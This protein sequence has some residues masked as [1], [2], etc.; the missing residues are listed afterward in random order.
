MKKLL[1]IVFVFCSYFGYGQ[2]LP[3]SDTFCAGTPVNLSTADSSLSYAWDT[4]AVNIAPTPPNAVTVATGGS[5]TGTQCYQVRYDKATGD[6]YGFNVNS[7]NSVRLFNY[8]TNPTNT[9]VA[10]ANLG[11][12]SGYL[13]SNGSTSYIDIVRDSTGLW[14]GFVT[15]GGHLVRIDFGTTFSTANVTAPTYT[16]INLSGIT[17]AIQITVMKYNGQWVAFIGNDGGGVNNITRL[18][19]G[20]NIQNA[21]PVITQLP[22]GSPTA[23]SHPSYFAVYHD[24]NAG[25]W[26]MLVSNKGTGAGGSG[27]SRYDFGANLQNNNPTAT[28]MTSLGGAFQFPRGITIIESCDSFYALATY[29]GF[30]GQFFGHLSFFNGTSYDITATPTVT[31]LGSLFTGNNTK[32][33]LTT[34]WNPLGAPTDSLYCITSSYQSTN[35]YQFPVYGLSAGGKVNYGPSSQTAFTFAPG[36]HNVRLFLD[37]GAQGHMEAYCKSIV[38][39][40]PGRPLLLPKDSTGCIGDSMILT[41]QIVGNQVPTPTYAWSTGATTQSIVVKTNGLYY[42]TVN[43]AGLCTT[44]NTDS[45]II[46]FVNRPAFTLGPD[47]TI[48]SGTPLTLAAIGNL[49]NGVIYSWSTGVSTPTISVNSTNN[50]TLTVTD[51]SCPGTATISVTAKPSPVVNLGNDTT[52]CQGYTQYINSS[53]PA[54]TTFL[55][56]TGSTDSTLAILTAGTYFLTASLNGCVSSDTVNINVTAAP[57]FF[58]GNDTTICDNEPLTIGTTNPLAT[59]YQWSTDST[60]VVYHTASFADS[61]YMRVLDP[62][63]DGHLTFTT[64]GIFSLTVT[65]AGGCSFADTI[66]VISQPGPHINFNI[67]RFD[68]MCKIHPYTIDPS[69]HE[70]MSYLW[71]TGATSQTLTVNETGTYWVKILSDNGCA[72]KDTVSIKMLTVPTQGLLGNDTTLCNDQELMIPPFIDSSL[73]FVWYSY[74]YKEV[75]SYDTTQKRLYIKDAPGVYYAY[76]TNRCGTTLD[77]INVQTKFCNIWFPNVFTPNND[78]VNDLIKPLGDLS[79]ITNYTLTIFD[80]WGAQMFSTTNPYEG[81]NGRFNNIPQQKGV[82]VYYMKFNYKNIPNDQKGNFTLLR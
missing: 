44:G 50:Y 78:G 72:A 45:A 38:A 53:Q 14:Y 12:L 15:D 65:V 54:G 10:Y 1:L 58:L 31:S 79:L 21:S 23:F 66:S 4:T 35:V 59:S 48:C 33:S 52:F 22:Q 36:P 8:G 7:N 5:F 9:P 41:P 57:V 61:S 18:D 56:N 43:G 46:Q 26:S 3:I 30:T 29:G 17:K 49:A 25:T 77:S 19:F 13:N 70:G 80:R 27:L 42:V 76:I 81:W 67:P 24:R 6:F 63:V 74:S 20:T 16:N 34:F 2:I 55:W 60:L 64:G 69:Y 28:S 73:H 68:T 71:S 51:I 47:T 11:S 32:T 39:V 75:Q 82:Y 62:T 37:Q 40:A